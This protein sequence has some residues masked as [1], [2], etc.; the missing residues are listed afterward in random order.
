MAG[1]DLVLAPETFLGPAWPDVTL[2]IGPGLG[3]R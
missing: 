2:I 3:A 1:Q